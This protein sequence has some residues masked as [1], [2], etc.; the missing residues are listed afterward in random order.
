MTT[1]TCRVCAD[2]Q[3][4]TPRERAIAR[5]VFADGES[6]QGMLLRQLWVSFGLGDMPASFFQDHMDDCEDALDSAGDA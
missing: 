4:L 1:A 3:R 5:M 2:W 6:D